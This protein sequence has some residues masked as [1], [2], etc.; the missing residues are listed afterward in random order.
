[1]ITLCHGDIFD[2]GAEA[3]VVPVNCV[4]VAGAGLAKEFAKR[5]PAWAECYKIACRKNGAHP[6]LSVFWPHNDT[7]RPII[8]SFP[9][10]KHWRD[11]SDIEMIKRGVWRLIPEVVNMGIESIAIPALGCGLG[12]LKW[13]DVW[14]ILEQFGLAMT[15]TVVMVYAPLEGAQA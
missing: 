3:L 9:T 7:A 10:K 8:I 2:S 5:F 13:E 6:E 11:K 12:G 14:P 4:G 15:D 1:M